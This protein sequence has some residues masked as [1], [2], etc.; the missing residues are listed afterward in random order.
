M[1][2][3]DKGA[4]RNGIAPLHSFGNDLQGAFLENLGTTGGL[5]GNDGTLLRNLR[6]KGAN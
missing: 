1:V 5:A 2:A 3:A 6:E 4:T